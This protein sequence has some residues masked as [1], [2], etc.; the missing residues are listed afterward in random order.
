MA[1]LVPAC[2]YGGQFGRRGTIGV[3]K[4]KAILCRK[5]KMNSILFFHFWCNKNYVEDT[6][7]LVDVLGSL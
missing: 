6:E 5:S 2:I 1:K 3:L 4:T 7:S